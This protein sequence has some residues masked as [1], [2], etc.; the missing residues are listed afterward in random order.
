M[1][2]GLTMTK[3]IILFSAVVAFAQCNSDC[4]WRKV[5]ALERIAAALEKAN[6]LEQ[7]TITSYEPPVYRPTE[8]TIKKTY[9]SKVNGRSLKAQPSDPS[10]MIDE[11]CISQCNRSYNT[12]SLVNFCIDHKCKENLDD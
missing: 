1:L 7:S 11:D 9:N 10:L 12:E 2:K 5:R 4:E 8:P 3:Y 6:Q